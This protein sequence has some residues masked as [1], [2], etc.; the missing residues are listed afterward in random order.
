M[1]MPPLGTGATHALGTS[2]LTILLPK[3]TLSHP[4]PAG[5]LSSKHTC[6]IQREIF[7]ALAHP[8]CRSPGRVQ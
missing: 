7:P 6:S 4:K 1:I 5:G 2:I 8:R 3:D